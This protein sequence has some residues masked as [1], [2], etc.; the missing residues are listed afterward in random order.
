MRARS[1]AAPV[2]RRRRSTE[3]L[4]TASSA[5]FGLL[6]SVRRSDRE[7]QVNQFA[8]A[9][10]LF[11]APRRARCA[12]RIPMLASHSQHPPV[13]LTIAANLA[14]LRPSNLEGSKDDRRGV[15]A[16]Q[17]LVA[18]SQPRSERSHDELRT[19]RGR[20]GR[21]DAASRFRTRAR[22]RDEFPDGAEC[23][24]QYLKERGEPSLVE[25]PLPRAPSPTWD[26]PSSHWR[27]RRTPCRYPGLARP[28]AVDPRPLHCRQRR[29]PPSWRR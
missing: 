1:M 7:R 11:L 23:E 3:A 2:S 4:E 16:A 13:G 5:C 10:P 8:G 22:C 21:R 24:R 19:P 20:F 12:D 27:T 18:H 26:R 15:Q 6:I 28:P 9:R 25:L 17:S 29:F 14:S